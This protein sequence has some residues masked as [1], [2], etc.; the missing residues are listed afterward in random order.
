MNAYEYISVVNPQD[1]E[2]ICVTDTRMKNNRWE[3][4]VKTAQKAWVLNSEKWIAPLGPGDPVLCRFERFVEILWDIQN[5][6]HVKQTGT[7]VL[8]PAKYPGFDHPQNRGF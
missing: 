2:D 8:E 4:S 5:G 1:T 3:S 6:G 7:R